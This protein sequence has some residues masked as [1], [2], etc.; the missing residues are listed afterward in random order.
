M[1]WE[2][3]PRKWSS[4]GKSYNLSLHR[5]IERFKTAKPTFSKA[6]DLLLAV[7]WIGNV[8][9]HGSVIRVLDVLDAVDILDRIIQQLYDTSPARIE[10]KAEEIIA[11]KGLPASHITSLPMPPF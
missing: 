8:G 6:A 11:R 1:D 5:R 2:G 4:N 9:S 7:K 10:R 3:I